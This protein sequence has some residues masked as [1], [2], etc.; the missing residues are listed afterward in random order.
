MYYL[1]QTVSATP[2][3]TVWVSCGSSGS[4]GGAS[5]LWSQTPAAC[6]TGLANVNGSCIAACPVGQELK[7]GMCQP[8]TCPTGTL[9]SGS[10]CVPAKLT[11]AQISSLFVA[12]CL[13]AAVA[14]GVRVIRRQ[15]TSF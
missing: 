11:A 12:V 15:I 10:A 1:G 6:S 9:V 4:A 13:V 5:G 3:D 2:V 14:Y 8:L 7:A